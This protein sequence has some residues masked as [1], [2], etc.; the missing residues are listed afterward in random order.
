MFGMSVRNW[1]DPIIEPWSFFSC[2]R[3]MP[4]ISSICLEGTMPMTVAVPPRPNMLKAC[5]L[6]ALRPIASK[7]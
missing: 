4:R 6:V 2:N 7:L 3:S 5:S 1:F